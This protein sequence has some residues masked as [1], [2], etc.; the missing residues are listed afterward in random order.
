MIVNQQSLLDAAPIA[1]MAVGKQR[2]HGVS[3]GLSEAGY[4]I[5]IAEDVRFLPCE[6]KTLV[7]D[8]VFPGLFVLASSMETFQI[9]DYLIGVLHDKSTH[10]RRG[11][12]V[13]NTVLECGWKGILT[14]ELVYHGR[15]ELHIPSG[16]G[17]GQVLFSRIENPIN[18]AGKYQNQEAGAQEA[19]Y[20]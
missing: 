7:N 16:S 15:D 17:I 20:E 6:N 14:I 13:F 1:D 19:R 4:D 18:Y 10:A 11:L 2:L 8:L 5:R 12:S 3:H 9:P